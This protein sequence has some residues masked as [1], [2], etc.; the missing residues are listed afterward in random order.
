MKTFGIFGS[1]FGLYGYLPAVLNLGHSAQIP[2]RYLKTFES[3]SELV[4]YRDK[5]SVRE[6]DN[7]IIETS[8]AIVMAKDS[9]SQLEF[10]QNIIHR[11]KF[12]FLEK[13]LA[14]NIHSHTRALNF[15]IEEEVNFAVAYLFPYADWYKA[16]LE[17]SKSYPVDI[18]FTWKITKPLSTWKNSENLG[19]GIR[20]YYFIHFAPLICDLGVDLVNSKVELRENSNSLHFLVTSLNSTTRLG[21]TFSYSSESRF[22]LVVQD[23]V[24]D[25]LLCS[26]DNHSPFGESGRPHV[27]DSRI[28]YLQSYVRESLASANTT[29]SVEIEQVVLA[30]RSLKPTIQSG[31][32]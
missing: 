32:I 15:L 8:N 30:I 17:S 19:G 25:K 29:R 23:Y 14:P 1:G 20:S 22:Q 21:V 5:F 10:L 7:D 18:Q 3:R 2:A 28:P 27:F 12:L 13:P 9:N 11:D 16:V 6:V 31:T 26:F 4:C 24:R